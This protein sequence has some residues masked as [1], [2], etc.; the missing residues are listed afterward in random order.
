MKGG[1]LPEPPDAVIDVVLTPGVV[2]VTV[3]VTCVGRGGGVME[4]IEEEEEEE[5]LCCREP[6]MRMG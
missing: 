2:T 3:E 6:G 5:E 1:A 4:V